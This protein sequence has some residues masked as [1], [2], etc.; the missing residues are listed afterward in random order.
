[1]SGQRERLP[2]GRRGVTLVELLVVIVV[3]VIV[4]GGIVGLLLSNQRL[5][6][7]NAEQ[8]RVQQTVRAG[9]EVMAQ[10]LRELSPAL[11]DLL[12][13]GATELQVRTV[14]RAG[15]VC[16]IPN[17]SPLTV[18]VANRGQ[19]FQDDDLVTF[20]VDDDVDTATDDYWAT[21][22]VSGA[23]P[24]PG[25]PGQAGTQ[26]LQL[27]TLSPAAA[28]AEVQLGSLVRSFVTYTYRPVTLDGEVFLGR[29][30]AGGTVVPLVGP[31]D[32]ANGITF[33][34]RDEDGAVTTT[35]ADVAT[36]ELTLRASSA[37]RFESGREVN[38]VATRILHLR[39]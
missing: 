29:V 36:V 25:C 22:V 1:M 12:S 3:S 23:V 6:T 13:L 2:S 19:P 16:D 18:Q 39:N 28:S 21:G 34:Y 11:G 10:E 26:R 7:A 24:G 14:R 9:A 30:E 37:A 27:T 20:F 4:M 8:V 5:F 32:A 35:P 33:I 17:R 15:I 31:L 38:D